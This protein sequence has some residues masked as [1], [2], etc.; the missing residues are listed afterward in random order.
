MYRFLLTC[1]AFGA[2]A[3]MLIGGL[4][5]SF[6]ASTAEGSSASIGLSAIRQCTAAG[7]MQTPLEAFADSSA[8][9]R[10][11]AAT[12]AAALMAGGLLLALAVSA[13]TGMIHRLLVRTTMIALACAGVCVLIFVWLAPQLASMSAGYSMI[14]YFAGMAAALVAVLM[15]RRQVVAPAPTAS[16]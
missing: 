5:T 8:W 9:V 2:A 15:A 4:T 13:A 10:A 6:W 3:L 12:Y 16:L 14:A 11:G 1:C 7:C